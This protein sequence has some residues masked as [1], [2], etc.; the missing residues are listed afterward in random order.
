M[1]YIEEEQPRDL[2]R[3]ETCGR[4]WDVGTPEIYSLEVERP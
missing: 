1:R 3:T 2:T 4:C